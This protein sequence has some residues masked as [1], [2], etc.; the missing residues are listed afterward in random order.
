MKLREM[1][2]S[3]AV[4]DAGEYKYHQRPA[5]GIRGAPGDTVKRNV[6]N[7]MI[8]GNQVDDREWKS[9]FTKMYRAADA[10]A[11]DIS[12]E[13]LASPEFLESAREAFETN[14]PIDAF[15]QRHEQL[16]STPAIAGMYAEGFEGGEKESE[17]F[18]DDEHEEDEGFES[19]GPVTSK[20]EDP[21]SSKK[22]SEFKGAPADPEMGFGKPTFGHEFGEVPEP[23]TDPEDGMWHAAYDGDGFGE[24]DEI[25]FG[26]HERQTGEPSH[27]DDVDVRFAEHEPEEHASAKD[28]ASMKQLRKLAGAEQLATARKW[29]DPHPAERDRE[30]VPPNKRPRWSGADEVEYEYH[31]TLGMIPSKRW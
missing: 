27:D 30:H 12:P 14:T 6:F 19:D 24:T 20:I 15:L 5:S 22:S 18:E 8:P 13:V 2:P 11:Y 29:G 3:E 10:G 31:P 25:G 1:F 23:S 9:W 21:T 17:G 16:N 4:G 7:S 28:E 26:G